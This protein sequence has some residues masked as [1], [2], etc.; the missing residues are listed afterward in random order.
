MDFKERQAQWEEIERL[1]K[2]VEGRLKH[3]EYL[4]TSPEQVFSVVPEQS[5][6]SNSRSK[7][8]ERLLEE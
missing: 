3:I 8:F 7:W 4:K 1:E 5:L 6:E 2:S